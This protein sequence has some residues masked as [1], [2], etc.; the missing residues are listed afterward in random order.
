VRHHLLVITQEIASG[1]VWAH[2]FGPLLGRSQLATD[3][4]SLLPFV[5]PAQGGALPPIVCCKSRWSP[6]L[7]AFA[8]AEGALF[9]WQTGLQAESPFPL[10]PEAVCAIGG[11]DRIRW[12]DARHRREWSWRA[13]APT[14]DPTPDATVEPGDGGVLFGCPDRT[15]GLIAC[16]TP[17]GIWVV[18]CPRQAPVRLLAPEG[19][20]VFGAIVRP[21]SDGG[22]ALLLLEP[23]RHTIRCAGPHAS[24]TVTRSSSQITA[25]CA[26]TASPDVAWRTEDGQICVWS[27]AHH[28]LTLQ[29]LPPEGR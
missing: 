2:G 19:A 27:L 3:L 8:D 23:D 24:T 4:G 25:V 9:G 22:T 5:A 11:G 1:R 16:E 7:V 26:S 20:Q 10:C 15:N 14:A 6:H 28:A 13:D 18:T 12:V 29:R 21:A 17:G